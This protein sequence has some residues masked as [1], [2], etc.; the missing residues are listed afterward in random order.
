[1]S[2]GLLLTSDRAAG[3][4]SRA[5]MESNVGSYNY[6]NISEA[7][8]YGATFCGLLNCTLPS[9]ACNMTCIRSKDTHVAMDAWSKATDE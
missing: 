9:K 4:F 5:I 3:L 1:M 2:I 6:K 7:S 8:L